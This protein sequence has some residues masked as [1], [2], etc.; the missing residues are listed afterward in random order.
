MPLGGAPSDTV[1]A[2]RRAR[3][4]PHGLAG[5]RRPLLRRRRERRRRACRAA[6]ARRALRGH[7]R[8]GDVGRRA[9][10]ARRRPAA[11]RRVQPRRPGRA[12]PS[13]GSPTRRRRRD[14]RAARRG[15]PRDG[16]DRRRRGRESRGG[17]SIAAFSSRGLV[18]DGGL[19]PE[20]RG[21]GRLGAD[22][23]ARP[24]RRRRGSLRDDQRDERR[25]RGDRRASQRSSRRVGRR[26]AR[27]GCTGCSS[28]RR[29]APIS[30]RPRRAPVS[31]I[32]AQR[33]SRRCSPSRRSSRSARCGTA[34][35]RAGAPRSRTSRRAGSSVSI[36]SAAI[37]PKGVEITVD[38]QR[39]RIRPGGS[40]D[41]VVRADTSNLSVGGRRCDRRARSAARRLARG[42]RPVGRRGARRRRPRLAGRHRRT[43]GTRVSD[44][45]PAALSFV[46]GVGDGDAR[47]AGARRRA[48]RGRALARRDAP[49]AARAPPRAAARP[50]HVRAH[51][52]GGRRASG[53]RAGHVH[54]S[55]CVAFPGDGT[56]ASR[57]TRSSIA[58]A[59]GGPILAP[60]SR[61]REATL[62]VNR[63]GGVPSPR[64][65][66]RAG[67]GAAPP[68]RRDLRA[69]S[70]SDPRSL[71][72]QEGR[73]GL[74]P[75]V[76]GRRVDRGLPGLPRDPQHRARAVEGRHPLPPRRHARRGQVARDVD[77]LEVRADG[78]AVRRREGRR[79]LQS[80][81][82]LAPAS[83][84]G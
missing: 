64:E 35:S 32:S 6:A 73:R 60:S 77:D 52:D 3:R 15:H 37:A 67:E 42:A 66:V 13:S 43:T 69:R 23:G 83:S 45:T 26:S 1:T 63:R 30:T 57:R 40:A 33:S 9:R 47:P 24:R 79:R 7:R 68:S 70:E 31:S 4:S 2:G 22:V 11:G 5:D 25:G 27:A 46:A 10:G 41:V 58:S 49:R 29:S 72:V 61:A 19:K 53:S 18:L 51:R 74:D 17:G 84:S 50:V 44:A 56:A 16:L 28:D 80:E 75:G 82:A 54:D 8:G 76:D 14:P 12:F 81:D 20:P 55:R 36:G 71:A 21:A 65:P 38:P 34:R 39:V 62:D 48:P 78:P 59:D